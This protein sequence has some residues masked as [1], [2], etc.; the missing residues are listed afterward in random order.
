[1]AIPHIDTFEYD[2]ADEIKRKEASIGDIASAGGDL[3]NRPDKKTPSFVFIL[4]SLIIL[5]IAG[6]AAYFGYEYYINKLNPPQPVVPIQIPQANDTT[7]LPSLS[8]GFPENIGRFISNVKRS[9]DGYTLTINS[10]SP[11]FTYIF[12]NENNY[13]GDVAYALGEERP[14]IGEDTFIFTDV[15]INNQNMR[16]GNSASSTLVYAF[17][18]STYLLFATST[19]SIL[20]LRSAIVH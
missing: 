7:L 12:N 20:V 19:E 5:I 15:T 14:L 3:G 4:L 9:P 1:M 13:A 18:N 16:V 6:G 8:P 2:I 10:Y 17:V 11:V